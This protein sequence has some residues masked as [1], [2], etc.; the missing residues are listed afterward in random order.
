MALWR[1]DHTGRPVPA[2]RIHHCDAGRSIRRFDSPKPLHCRAYRPR[3]APSVTPTITPSPS[4]SW[5]CSKTKPP[6]SDHRF[7]PGRC[8]PWPTS[9]PSSCTTSTGTTTT[10]QPVRPRHT[11]GVRPR[12]R[13]SQHPLTV[14]RRRQQE[15]SMKPGVHRRSHQGQPGRCAVRAHSWDESSLPLDIE[16][17]HD[18]SRNQRICGSHTPSARSRHALA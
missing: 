6:P 14:R 11:R 2:G 3:S 12:L 5:A 17:E 15:D 16:R 7:G 4:R 9:K 8:A 10:A 18:H 1:R 13:R